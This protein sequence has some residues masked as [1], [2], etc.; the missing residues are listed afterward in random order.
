MQK[1]SASHPLRG[2]ITGLQPVAVILS[3]DIQPQR[4]ALFDKY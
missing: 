1:L 4:V 3:P 2:I